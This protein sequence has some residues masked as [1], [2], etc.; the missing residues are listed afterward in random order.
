LALGVWHVLYIFLVPTSLNKYDLMYSSW[1][2]K[3]YVTDLLLLLPRSPQFSLPLP[4]WVPGSQ[5]ELGDCDFLL[6]FGMVTANFISF[7]S[8]ECSHALR[9]RYFRKTALGS[10]EVIRTRWRSTYFTECC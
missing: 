4:S 8:T 1:E 5:S 6:H 10:Q 2:M 7:Q 3:F 9:M